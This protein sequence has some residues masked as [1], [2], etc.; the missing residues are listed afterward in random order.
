MFIKEFLSQ[1]RNDFTAMMEC[2]HCGSAHKLT[3]GYDDD[4]YH[5]NVIPAMTC[6]ACG[7][8]R[9]GEVPEVK[10]DN[11]FLHVPAITPA[12]AG[13]GDAE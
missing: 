6:K 2:Q 5:L 13:Y 4:N 1:H 3:S 8:N 11:G 12:Q 9:D 10:N 7:R